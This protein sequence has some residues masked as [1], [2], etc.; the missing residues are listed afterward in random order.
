[1]A[2]CQVPDRYSAILNQTALFSYSLQ[3]DSSVTV[4]IKIFP[5]KI[6]LHI[7]KIK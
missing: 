5:L 4:D 3:E 7:L 2:L 1:M 6:Y